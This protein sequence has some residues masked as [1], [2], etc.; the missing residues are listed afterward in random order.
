MGGVA[1]CICPFSWTGS[2]CQEA[3]CPQESAAVQRAGWGEPA[4]LLCA[5]SPVYMEANVC[6]QT[7]AAVAR[8]TLDH[9]VKRGRSSDL[10]GTAEVQR[11]QSRHLNDVYEDRYSFPK[12]CF[13]LFVLMCT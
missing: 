5:V 3:I 10:Y 1:K 7:N 11:D 6:L 13:F 9:A 8:L 12:W 4:T 2:K